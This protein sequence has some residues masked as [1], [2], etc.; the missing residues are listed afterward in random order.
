MNFIYF[1]LCFYFDSDDIY[2]ASGHIWY[3]P[4]SN[5]YKSKDSKLRL[6]SH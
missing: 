6:K 4:G 1:L 3:S 5:I 2:W